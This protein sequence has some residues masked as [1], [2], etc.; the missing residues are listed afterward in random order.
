MEYVAG[1]DI[2]QHLREKPETANDLFVQ[3]IEGF[4]YL[5]RQ[6]ILH[7][8]IRPLNI[9]VSDN[10]I[11]KIIDLGFGKQI[12]RPSDFDKSISLNWWCEPPVDFSLG[13]YD[14]ATE[15]YF[16][17]KL[18]EKFVVEMNLEDF[19]HKGLL[20]RMCHRDP[21]LRLQ[22]FADTRSEMHRQHAADITFFG[23]ER[24]AY[25]SFADAVTKHLTKIETGSKYQDDLVLIRNHL[26]TAYRNCMLEEH[27]PDCSAILSILI[28]GGY[29]Y[30]RAGFSTKALK[31]FID[32]LRSATLAKQRVILANLH[33]RLDA[34]TRYEKPDEDDV[35]F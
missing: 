1:K 25:T 31:A 18:F 29:S 21:Q 3:A 15:V 12:E 27:L 34:V 8:D 4:A 35:P 33:S 26:E 13:K 30:R 20:S 11:L 19:K 10:G 9:L 28:R 22:S 23:Q 24:S 5:E 32:L 6:A 16:V 7:R 17:G 14:H 2:E